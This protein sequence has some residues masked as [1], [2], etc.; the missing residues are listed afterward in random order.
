MSLIPW[1]PKEKC[2]LTRT[3]S[4]LLIGQVKRG[5]RKDVD[6]SNMKVIGDP[7]EEFQWSMGL[8]REI[9]KKVWRYLL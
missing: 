7:E 9:E 8:K 1:K 2:V 5:L 3:V 6:F 4:V